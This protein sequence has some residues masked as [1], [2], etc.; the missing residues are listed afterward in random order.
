MGY[1]D[2]PHQS[3]ELCGIFVDHGYENFVSPA[4]RGR[5]TWDVTN[6]T[7]LWLK[8]LS[9]SRIVHHQFCSP[10]SSAEMKLHLFRPRGNYR[11]QYSGNFVLQHGCS[12]W[13][14]SGRWN[15]W[16]VGTRRASSAYT[17]DT[18]LRGFHRNEMIYVLIGRFL[19]DI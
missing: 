13:D 12:S 5:D 3:P 9:V 17:D 4:A 1:H 6:T 18:G 16:G 15:Q 2:N 10:A 11:I 14:G 7:V 19:L 8:I